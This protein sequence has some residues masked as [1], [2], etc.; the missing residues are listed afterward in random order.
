MS[1]T[2]QIYVIFS[3][4]L[5]TFCD[6][7]GMLRLPS[8]HSFDKIPTPF[9]YYDM[10]LLGETL[11]TLSAMAEKYCIKVHYAMKANY[12]GKIMR[13]IAERG[14][15]ADCVTANEAEWAVKNGFVPGKLMFAGVGKTDDE[16]RRCLLLGI[17]AFNCESIQELQVIDSIAGE[18]GLRARV[19]IRMNPNVDAHTHRYI[20][21][22][23]EENKFGIETY[24]IDSLVSTLKTCRNVDFTGL[25]FHVGSQILDSIEEV[26]RLTCERAGEIV[27]AF[28]DRGLE[29]GSIDLGGG[30]GV[31]YAD[32]DSALVP[33][34]EKW[35]STIDKY[36]RRRPEQVVRVEPGRSVV[37]QCGSLISR[38]LYVKPARTKT[39]LILDAGMNDLIRPALY[40]AFHLIENL[41]AGFRGEEVMQDYDVVGPVCES[42]DVW[43]N[44]RE[45]PLS[46]RGDL[47]AIR[48]AG[49]YGSTMS[50]RYN[51]RD[52]AK[53]VFSDEI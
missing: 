49:A 29:V 43:G 14:F 13:K 21:T 11:D 53:A 50:S 26:F 41:S 42:D 3:L 12:E 4:F 18:M 51:L 33:D 24:A 22:G 5:R 44:N 28:E 8:P 36:L 52:L 32:P 17:G 46:L 30:L 6:Y 1:G 48:S 7:L 45:L 16:I 39:F 40:G 27:K 19:G 23:L 20:T 37:A 10:G 25:H 2:A 31:L 15:G 35:F 34:F 9:Y 38:V 47:M